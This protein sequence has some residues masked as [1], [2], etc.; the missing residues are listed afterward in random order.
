MLFLTLLALEGM[1]RIAYY[2]AYGQGYGGGRADTPTAANIPQ[3]ANRDPETWRIRHPFYGFIDSA[4][5]LADNVLNVMPPQQRQEDTV[6]IGLL[7]GSLAEELRPFLQSALDDWFA[8]NNLPRRPLVLRLATGGVKQPQ[9]T[10]I[11]ANTL[12]L[13]GEFDLLVNLDGFNE[14]I[15]SAGWNP[16]DSVFPLF[17]TSWDKQVSL[18]NAEFLL[19]GRIGALRREQARRAAAGEMIPLRWSAVFGLANRYRRERI[20][21]EII[22]LNHQLAAVAADYN[23]EKHGPRGWPRS[24]GELWP[25]AARVWYRGAV[26]LNRLAELAGADYYHFLQPNQYVPDSKPLS[27]EELAD[28][29]D[30]EGQTR[31]FIRQGYPLLTEFNR[32]LQGQGVN[33][34]D[35]TGIFADH[36]ETLYRDICCHLNVRGNELLAAEMARLMAPALRRRSGESP[37]GPVSALDA[38]R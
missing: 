27:P 26:T 7:G 2:A 36:P 22:Q 35:L 23:L 33:Y 31:A 38:A 18:T 3:D 14:I 10:M 32:D 19:A 34:F 28:A 13:G 12:L 1:A 11:L 5:H 9:Q 15:F 37:V 30:A 25:A 16:R 24:E 17:P 29:Y 20:A 6:V 21:T 8:A 4:P